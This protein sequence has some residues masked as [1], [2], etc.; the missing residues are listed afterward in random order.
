ML[1]LLCLIAFT[2]HLVAQTG[3]IPADRPRARPPSALTGWADWE[4]G[5]E[6]LKRIEVP[7]AP[8]RSAEEEAKTFKLAPGYRAELVAC[9]PMV[10]CPIFFEFDPEGRI[11]VV[12]Y[13]GYMRDVKGSGEGDPICRVVVLEDT[14]DDG[15]ADKSTVFLDRLVMPRSFA[16]VKGGIL[17]QE[18]PKLWFCADKDGDLRCDERTQVGTMGVGGNPQHTANGLRRGIDNWLHCADWPHRYQW[19]DGKLIDEPTLHRGQFGVSFDETG[20]FISCYENSAMHMDLLPAE[21]LMRHQNLA[22]LAQRGGRGG[23]GVNVNVAKD[24][25]ECFPIRV[26]PA[27]TLGALELRDDGRLRTY[28]IVSGTCFY[29]GDQFPPEMHGNVFVPDSAGHLVGT[30]KLDGDVYPHATRFFPP[31]Q[32]L[33]ASTDE[34]FRP[35][36]AR[37]GPDGALYLA[38]MYHGIIE[39]VIFIVPWLTKQIE[40]RKL[41]EGNDHGRIWRIVHEKG[42]KREKGS[43]G[44]LVKMLGHP[45]GWQRNTAQRLLVERGEDIGDPNRFETPLHRLHALWTLEGMGKLTPAHLQKA[46]ND[47]DPRVRAA[48]ARLGAEIALND[49]PDAS[50]R[51]HALLSPKPLSAIA[52]HLTRHENDLSRIAAMT[53]IHGKE[54]ALLQLLLKWPQST[55]H[56]IETLKLLSQL[57]CMDGKAEIILAKMAEMAIWQRGALL[58]G[59]LASQAKLTL[60]A[61]PAFLD[62]MAENRDIAARERLQRLRMALNW[63]GAENLTLSARK[64]PL[65]DAAKQQIERGAAVYQSVCGLCHQPTG[66]GVPNVAPPLAESTWVT[67]EPERLIRIALHGLYGEIE[68]NG[69]KWNLAM[70]GQGMNPLL[71]D[72]KLADVLSCIR[73][74]WGNEAAPITAAQITA[75]REQTKDRKMPWTADTLMQVDVKGGGAIQ[76]DAEGVFILP[77]SAA[78]TYGQKLAYRPSL[79]VLAPWRIA[80]DV[81]EWTIDVS[82]DDEFEV[83][84]TLAA[85]EA[86]AGDAYVLEGESASVTGVVKSTGGYESFAEQFAGRL[87]LKSGVQKLLMRPEGTLKQELADVRAVRLRKSNSR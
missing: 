82:A 86:S 79:N 63:P 12:E 23:F 20:R 51:L 87:C 73:N 62:E 68:V 14:N 57:A 2:A 18:P 1:R 3:T 60:K 75:V 49:E 30:L 43:D 59:F 26:T 36:N 5:E 39:H 47:P 55:A 70:P 35:V 25:A 45:N 56:R 19:K 77:A 46:A 72:A 11:W 33:I 37:V 8:V 52:E 69:Q 13:Q 50:V 67:G 85:D 29:D 76:A 54:I 9:E 61:K 81:A 28:T 16:F 78:K 15:K 74:A 7:P 42:A 71:D 4:K 31:E 48:A 21:A 58:D 44:D 80:T 83:F 53:T 66:Y 17:L 41:Y 65:S 32:E 34:R 27:V 24:A 38:D 40:Q 22:K 64:Q 6:L 84:V 10:Q